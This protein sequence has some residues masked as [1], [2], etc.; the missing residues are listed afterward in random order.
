MDRRVFYETHWPKV[1]G[2]GSSFGDPVWS[3]PVRVTIEDKH[4]PPPDP[5]CGAYFVFIDG[6][7]VTRVSL[8]RETVH[9]L[10]D[11]RLQEP[12][13]VCLE[14]E[15][16]AEGILAELSI[17]VRMP[18]R[19]PPPGTMLLWDG[20]MVIKIAVGAVLRSFHEY[21]YPG[22]RQ[23]ELEDMLACV[24]GDPLPTDPL[25]AVMEDARRLAELLHEP[26]DEREQG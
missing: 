20:P 16:S 23:L 4:G 10:M 26:E 24:I 11:H 25:D 6:R 18:L 8:A 15:E 2:T 17:Q 14:G 22:D 9:V 19:R 1:P 12:V 3:E 13:R 21:R 7:P 5:Y